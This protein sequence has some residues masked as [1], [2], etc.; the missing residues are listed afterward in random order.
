M[1]SDRT[2]NLGN[3]TCPK[4]AGFTLL[5]F[6]LTQLAWPLPVSAQDTLRTESISQT[7]GLEELKAKFGEEQKDSS[8]STPALAAAGMEEVDIEVEGSNGPIKWKVP[9][10]IKQSIDQLASLEKLPLDQAVKELRA[11]LDV[12]VRD[13]YSPPGSIFVER[14]YEGLFLWALE[15]LSEESLIREVDMLLEEILGFADHWL[16]T[17]FSPSHENDNALEGWWYILV[18]SLVL[19]HRLE[20]V[21]PKG[22]LT[23]IHLETIRDLYRIFLGKTEAYYQKGRAK[24]DP[25]EFYEKR[26]FE[27]VKSQPALETVVGRLFH[28]WQR[29]TTEGSQKSYGMV[30]QLGGEAFLG[31]LR[32]IFTGG[33]TPKSPEEV[34]KETTLQQKLAQQLFQLQVAATPRG[35]EAIQAWDNPPQY[36]IKIS[37]ASDLVL[38]SPIDQFSSYEDQRAEMPNGWLF[39]LNWLD[40]MGKAGFRRWTFTSPRDYLAAIFQ[41]SSE[42]GDRRTIQEFLKIL[43]EYLGSPGAIPLRT[44]LMLLTESSPPS[45]N[46]ALE[47]WEKVQ[48]LKR[49]HGAELQLIDMDAAGASLLMKALPERI[50]QIQAK[51]LFIGRLPG[52]RPSYYFPELPKAMVEIHQLKAKPHYET[53]LFSLAEAFRYVGN[54]IGESRGW[55]E[56]R[57][58]ALPIQTNELLF[59]SYG[60]Q[61]LDH[62]ATWT[63]QRLDA[64]VISSDPERPDQEI[65]PVP[66]VADTG[67]KTGP[68]NLMPVGTIPPSKQAGLEEKRI[69]L[70]GPVNFQ[71]QFPAVDGPPGTK[72]VVLVPADI[73]MT[74][75]LY[76]DPTLLSG[77]EEI[78]AKERHSLPKDVQINVRQVPDSADFLKKPGA[79][80]WHWLTGRL[81]KQNILPEVELDNAQPMPRLVSIVLFALHGS[82]AKLEA[83]I[84]VLTLQDAQGNT[85]Y[86]YFV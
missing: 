13:P 3:L 37:Q 28:N 80:F 75:N 35:E 54:R 1:G 49:R 50:K 74:I 66:E 46:Q 59:S 25:K 42:H 18:R 81:Y 84:G 47:F 17:G 45:V 83:I 67:L 26:L 48:E 76:A 10:V 64:L 22:E 72:G 43:E 32:S 4:V 56:Y 8:L 40:Q 78:V 31:E 70:M 71:Q 77:L 20:Q 58:A 27:L 51:Q 60:N 14:K 68:E 55:G 33:S 9:T 34:A 61:L 2:R 19:E 41:W 62:Q 24:R 44:F 86:A 5:I 15:H 52:I 12:D 39:Q 82:G 36:L 21:T 79:V 57:S 38:L 7:A 6:L 73:Q 30:R 11:A 85:V 69:V 23:R 65:S 63:I 29:W 16:D 53:R